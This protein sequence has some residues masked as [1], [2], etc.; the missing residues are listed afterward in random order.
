VFMNILI[1]AYFACNLL[2][3]LVF[4]VSALFDSPAP[5]R[6][7]ELVVASVVFFFLGIPIALVTALA[8]LFPSSMLKRTFIRRKTSDS[9][10]P[11]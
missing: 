2:I 11:G 3:G 1:C 8:A 6:K 5:P 7:G 9:L 10:H 4:H